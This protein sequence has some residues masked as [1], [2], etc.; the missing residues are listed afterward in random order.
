MENEDF[1]CRGGLFNCTRL[2]EARGA[3]LLR[4]ASPTPLEPG[5]LAT[6]SEGTTR[7]LEGSRLDFLTLSG[8]PL[9]RLLSEPG[10]QLAQVEVRLVKKCRVRAVRV[11]DARWEGTGSGVI[12]V[13]ARVHRSWVELER[14]DCF[15]PEDLESVIPT[16]DEKRGAAEKEDAVEH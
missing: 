13:P 14:P 11:R 3:L 9:M 16:P 12:A 5:A 7:S 8:A 10:G 1:E 15:A 2:A 6:W 4:T